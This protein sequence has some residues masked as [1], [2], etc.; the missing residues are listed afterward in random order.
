M[1]KRP[2]DFKTGGEMLKPEEIKSIEDVLEWLSSTM[3]VTPYGKVGIEVDMVDG[4]PMYSRLH[5]KPN[6]KLGFDEKT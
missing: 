5:W 6:I 1:I 2:A 3:E 4:K